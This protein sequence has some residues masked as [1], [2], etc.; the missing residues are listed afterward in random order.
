MTERFYSFVSTKCGADCV[1]SIFLCVPEK[2]A[3]NEKEAK[4]FALLSGWI[5][6]AEI[7]AAVLIVMII[8][9]GWND[10]S[11]D[12]ISIFYNKYKNEFKSPSG[13]SIPGR[14]GIIWLW[15]TMIYAV[16]YDEGADYLGNV[17]VKHPNLFAGAALFNGGASDFSPMNERTSHWFVTHPTSDYVF[18]NKDIPLPVWVFGYAKNTDLTVNYFSETNHVDQTDSY[19]VN[20][21][22]VVIHYNKKEPAQQ[23]RISTKTS[24]NDLNIAKTI[25][26]EFFNK[27]IR[28]KNSPDGT[29]KQYSGRNDYYTSNRF[30]HYNLNVGELE[31]PYSV[32]IPSGLKVNDVK[33]LPLVISLHGRG[34]PTW[35]FS[36][37]NGW[38]ILADETKEFIV[39][40]PDSKYNIWQ[41]ERDYD[42]IE[43]ILNDVSKNYEYD[44]ERVY[45][46]G[47]SN[48]AIFT[49]QQAST[50]PWLF[51]AVSPWNGP[52][53]EECRKANIASYVYHPD[54]IDSGYELPIW[55]IVGDSDTKAGSYRDDELEI[56]LPLNGCIT[57]N[58][59]T[60]SDEYTKKNNYIE[61]DRFNTKVY[62][63]VDKEIRV[64]L[65][66]MKNMPH[67]AIFDESRATW[68]FMKRFRRPNK[69]KHVE[70][71][72]T[73]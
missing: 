20:G 51:A 49:C 26:N 40:Y 61:G 10:Y 8:P 9:N 12:A 16:G 45:L 62:S 57:D 3:I 5:D 4:E 36:E 43:A 66:V 46:T 7:N 29:I 11:L 56:V 25:M 17:L 15:E 41:I 1:Q 50:H 42:S 35:V 38:D 44:P 39:V 60:L 13:I 68:N 63:N 32:H 24:G 72:T 69:N 48:G 47:F 54:F 2:Y 65:T 73:K 18:Y 22:D 67:G 59:E 37:K 58:V 64:G 52:G 55:I 53:I 14:N 33:G 6:Q 34:E 70:E 30:K 21:I 28:W 19:S 27:S 71:I 31:Y 23:I